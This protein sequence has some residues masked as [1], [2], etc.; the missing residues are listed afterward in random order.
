MTFPPELFD[1]IIDHL[2]DDKQALLQC[3]TVCRGWLNSA[4]YHL[5]YTMEFAI[6]DPKPRL[7]DLTDFVKSNTTVAACIRI[8]RVQPTFGPASNP[9]EMQVLAA[10][11][12]ALPNL[13]AINL[14]QMKLDHTRQNST[15]ETKEEPQVASR[16]VQ[17][18]SIRTV[19]QTHSMA[20]ILEDLCLF[21]SLK[22]LELSFISWRPDSEGETPHLATP[23]PLELETL[24]V[25]LMT[26]P[27][28]LF[29]YIQSTPSVHT[30]TT[31]CLFGLR[32]PDVPSAG[33]L[34]Q[35]LGMTLQ[36]FSLSMEHF[37][38][39]VGWDGMSVILVEDT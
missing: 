35:D 30:L 23:T 2:H 5:F 19:L 15:N 16:S 17:S 4:R 39:P 25:G 14:S 32:I 13:R 1:N 28:Q 18:L 27:S 38:S 31:L 9:L 6:P 11:A 33:L 26:D 12:R 21:P 29:R 7:L 8:L 20:N 10:V 37:Q 22:N 36:H 24:T 34:L 3:A